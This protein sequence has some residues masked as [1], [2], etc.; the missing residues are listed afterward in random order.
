[1]IVGRCRWL[2]VL[3][4][5]AVFPS[6]HATAGTIAW[7]SAAPITG[8]A[9][10]VTSGSLLYAYNFGRPAVPAAIVNGVSF[11]PF[12]IPDG[13]VSTV[14]VGDVTLTESPDSL[15][16]LDS[17]GSTSSPFA[18]L[19]ADYQA[20]LGSAAYAAAAGT[21]TVTLGGLTPGRPYLVQ[22]WTNDSS[23]TFFSLTTSSGS[24]SV[25]L[26]SNP[27]QL[28]GSLGQYAIGIFLADAAT[29]EFTL[30][31]SAAGGGG[32]NPDYPIITAIQ[33]REIPEISADSAVTA[34]ALATA[35][36][37]AERSRRRRSKA[38]VT[39]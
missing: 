18:S 35:A 34:T 30:T 8:D 14:S 9:D 17:F 2:L 25:T 27:D 12:A 11:T 6:A 22:W 39:A 29:Q 31:G 5:T 4:C 32:K 21:V 10:V 1:M 19:S 37:F 23:V 26:D 16:A 15:F 3:V 33:V 20:L 28:D 13:G 36:A 7:G 24:P 38:A